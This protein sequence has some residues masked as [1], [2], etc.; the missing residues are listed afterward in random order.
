MKFVAK[1]VT[2]KSTVGLK[3][4]EVG[5]LIR[6]LRQ[7]TQLSQVQFAA[8]LGVSFG[9]IN[10]WENGH[11]QPSPLAVKRIHALVV[12]LSHSSSEKLQ[13]ESKRLVERYF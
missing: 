11:M 10:R 2:F 3:Q 9:T 7:L 12:E 13:E 5:K 1:T 4:P 8:V 6:K